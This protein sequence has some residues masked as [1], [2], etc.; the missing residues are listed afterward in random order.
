[1]RYRFLR[2]KDGKEKAFTLSYDDGIPSDARL[3]EIADRYGIKVTLNVNSEFMC[4]GR[5]TAEQL[6]EMTK[7][8]G[9][10][11]AIHGARH[12]APGK[13]SLV[14]GINDALTCRRDLEKSFNRIIRGMAYPD[15]GITKLYGGV[16][17]EQVKDY[18]KSLGIAYARSLGGDNDRFDLPNDFYEW[19][20]TAHHRN[21]R[22]MEYL[23]KFLADEIKDKYLAIRTPMLFYLW[24]HTYEFN[25]DDNWDLLEEICE[26]AGGRDDIWYATN[27]EICDYVNAYYQLQFNVENTKVYNPTAQTVWFDADGKLFCVTPGE[28]KDLVW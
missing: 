4:G 11:I 24:G 15:S 5:L 23:D 6:Y 28:T 8:G 25:N 20:P 10:E 18:L 3:I 16:T 13:A 22:V 12:I 2:F 26:K 14:D 21:P 7:A 19:I 27:I 17:K 1:M 9:H